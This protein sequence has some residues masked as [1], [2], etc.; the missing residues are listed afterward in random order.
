M[1]MHFSVH[2]HDD[3][4][5]R[6][7]AETAQKVTI[8]VCDC[9]TKA[10]AQHMQKSLNSAPNETQKQVIAAIGIELL[11]DLAQSA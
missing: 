10:L 3:G 5:Y 7:T 8:L 2:Q 6:L 11:Q 1:T 9:E 4:W